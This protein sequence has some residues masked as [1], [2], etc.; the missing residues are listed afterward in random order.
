MANTNDAVTVVAIFYTWRTTEFQIQFSGYTS[1]HVPTKTIII[2][3][4]PNMVMQYII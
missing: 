3:R 1:L 4:C 2:F